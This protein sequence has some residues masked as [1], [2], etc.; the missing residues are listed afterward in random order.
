MTT[1]MLWRFSDLKQRGVCNSRA[2][3]KLMVDHY[4]FP[5]G[6]MLT[7]NARVWTQD[8]VIAYYESRTSELKDVSFLHRN[9][10]KP[11][12]RRGRPPKLKKQKRAATGAEA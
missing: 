4:G 1:F 5:L 6:K 3:L 11:K 10:A 9:D 2:Q 7:P 12:G 8:E